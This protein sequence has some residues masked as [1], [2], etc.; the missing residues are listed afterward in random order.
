MLVIVCAGSFELIQSPQSVEEAW[1]LAE[2]LTDQTGIAHW[3]G[4]I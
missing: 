4:R 1:E 2:T 3:V